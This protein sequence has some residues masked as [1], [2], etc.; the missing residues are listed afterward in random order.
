MAVL[1]CLRRVSV[2]RTNGGVDGLE[3]GF[4]ESVRC[5]GSEL[6]I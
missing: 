1:S 5:R 2:V 3:V 4:A 6:G